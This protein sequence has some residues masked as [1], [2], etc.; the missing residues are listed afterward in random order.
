MKNKIHQL[1]LL[2]LL[3]ISAVSCQVLDRLAPS[4]PEPGVVVVPT[5]TPASI[6]TDIPA[7]SA[8]TDVQEQ[9]SAEPGVNPEDN[10]NA[11]P[12]LPATVP[13]KS[14]EEAGDANDFNLFESPAGY[15]FQHP[16][17]W[18]VADYFGQT[19]ATNDPAVL[20]TGTLEDD[21]LLILFVAGPAEDNAQSA[22]QLLNA[23]Q[24]DVLAG[25]LEKGSLTALVAAEPLAQG[26]AIGVQATY[27]LTTESGGNLRI[28]A[29]SLIK[30]D[31]Y[32]VTMSLQPEGNQTAQLEETLQSLELTA[33][34]YLVDAA[35][36]SLTQ[37]EL[38]AL[39]QELVGSE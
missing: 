39:N 15:R 26:G 16:A 18:D 38:E 27:Q 12:P 2:F 25:Y 3:V 24:Q 32:V 21:Q 23:V 29:I 28:Q 1:T 35:T 22:E 14:D 37:E 20:E 33:D 10:E 34:R 5:L 7:D 11:P 30:K 13:P 6:D 8:E 31:L 36:Y 19:I 4:Q 9:E 17:G